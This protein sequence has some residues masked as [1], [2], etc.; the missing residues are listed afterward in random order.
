MRIRKPGGDAAMLD[1]PP[2]ALLAPVDELIDTGVLIESDERLAFRHDITRD[3]VRASL[4]M[5]ARAALDRHAADV[6]LAAGA[7]P[8]EV[9]TQLAASAEPGDEL[10]IA[11]LLKAAEALAISD[12]G[13]AA[14]LSRRGLELAP[15]KHPLRGPLVAQTAL[16]LHAA[17]RVE[18]A[19]A[20]AGHVTARGT[21]IRAGG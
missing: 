20:F 16:L 9:A 11:T 21:S 6:L 2:S 8:V 12:P 5:S 7:T 19:S 17:A 10:A 13:A 3:A 18:E 4:P 14:D 15:R 1:Q